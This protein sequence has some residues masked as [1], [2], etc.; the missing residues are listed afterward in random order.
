MTDAAKPP[1]E[2]SESPRP[3]PE[4]EA[5]HDAEP[6]RDPA[7]ELRHNLRIGQQ[8]AGRN[9]FNAPLYAHTVRFDATGGEAPGVL[10]WWPLRDEFEDPPPSFVPPSHF[11]ALRRLVREQRVV[12]LTGGGC[13]NVTAAGAALRAAEHDPVVELAASPTT[14]S[15]LAS[16]EQVAAA[17]PAAGIVIPSVGEEALRGFGAAELRRLRGA[18]GEGASVILTTRAQPAPDAPA[19]ALPS[20]EALTPDAAEVVCAHAAAEP[21]VRERALTALALLPTDMPIG[22]GTA[23]RLADAARANADASPEQLAEL[24]SGRSDA[25]DEWLAGH[26]TA[27]H[28]AALAAAVTLDGVPSADVDA[29]AVA[30]RHLLEGELEPSDEPRRFGS[31]DR[32]WPAGVIALCRRPLGTYFGVQEAEVV[33]ICPPHSREWLFAQLWD[34][35][36]ADFRSSLLEWLRELAEHPSPRVRSGAAVTAGMLLAKEPVTAERELLRPW[37]LDGRLTLCECAG[38]AIG[39]P[40]LLGHDPTPARELA[41][42][43]SEPRSGAKRRR[44]AIAAYGG[45]FGAWDGGAAA[46]AQLWR[47]PTEPLG[48]TRDHDT[49]R[50]AERAQLR[51]AADDALAGL[52]AAGGEAGQVRATVISLLVTQAEEREERERA[53]GLLPKIMRRLARRDELARSS[54]AALLD[55]AEQ[56]SFAELTALLAHAFDTPPG[57]ASAR[58]ALWALLDALGAG[59]IDEEVVNRI[60]RGMKAG[61]RPGRRSGLGQQLERVLA[62]ERR[63]EGARGRAADAVHATFFSTPQEVQ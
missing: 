40:V 22:P 41:Y 63:G 27:E 39:I 28:V 35:L 24:V 38:L 57:F 36:G 44:A 33:E 17:E 46:P 7:D 45:P 34:R 52:V 56:T 15:L 29:E 18:L 10:T 21:E 14:Q 6:E 2:P 9:L 12:L 37:A 62:V 32:G 58:A 4:A 50:A 11:A 26:P 47:I 13:G 55:D 3:A 60:V 30:L 53:Y 54:L 51:R 1:S 20:L 19:H 61:A 59:R 5:G 43:W 8:T 25:L 31:A 16:I 42:V 48:A 49:Q 23:V